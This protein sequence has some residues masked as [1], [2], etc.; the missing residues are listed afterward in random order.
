MNDKSEAGF[1]SNHM[2]ISVFRVRGSI[3]GRRERNN[4]IRGVDTGIVR[5]S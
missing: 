1:R 5:A 2:F 3:E 4:R